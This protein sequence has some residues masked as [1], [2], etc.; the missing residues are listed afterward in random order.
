MSFIALVIHRESAAP[1]VNC[2]PRSAGHCKI[3]MS[4]SPSP[5][6]G[7]LAEKTSCKGVLFVLVGPSAVGKNTIMGR[8]MEQVPQLSQLP[9]ATTRAKRTNEEHGR[10]HVF[11]S[12]DQFHDMIA[13]DALIEHQEVYPGM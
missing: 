12:L 4:N 10:E 1:L 3:H 11:V 13:K 6:G 2:S 9:T 5:L 8:V 7:S